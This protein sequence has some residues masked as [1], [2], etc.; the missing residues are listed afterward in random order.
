MSVVNV[1]SRESK[2]LPV[3]YKSLSCPQCSREEKAPTASP[4]PPVVSL[5]WSPGLNLQLMPHICRM[6][7]QASLYKQK[8]KSYEMCDEWDNEA[9]FNVSFVTKL[10]VCC[11]RKPAEVIW[12]VP[13]ADDY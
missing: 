2:T 13:D 5:Q 11:C 10:C 1:T 8:E 7:D 3:A 12:L 9:E 6:F 4:Y